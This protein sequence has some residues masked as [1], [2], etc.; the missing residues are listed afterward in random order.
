VFYNNIKTALFEF[1]KENREVYMNNILCLIV[2]G[3]ILIF[4]FINRSI[5]GVGYNILKIFNLFWLFDFIAYAFNIY[6]F[7][8]LDDRVCCYAM[9]FISSTNIFYL[10]RKRDGSFYSIDEQMIFDDLCDNKKSIR[11]ITFLS[12]VCWIFSIKRLMKSIQIIS[13]V[14]MVGLRTMAYDDVTYTTIEKLSYQYFVQ[15]LFV[16]SIILFAI[17]I[18]IGKGK[19]HKKLI[20]V[21]MINATVYSLLFGGRALF[22]LVVMYFFFM[23]ILKSGGR[24]S[25][26]I[27]RQKKMLLIFAILVIV[28]MIYASLRVTRN[29][30]IIGEIGI[31]LT[32]GLGYLSECIKSGNLEFGIL[33]GRGMIGFI[34]DAIGLF[35]KIAGA[36]IKL[37]SEY[38]SDCTNGILTIGDGIR[39]NFTATAMG[40]MLLDFGSVGVLIGGGLYGCL[41][42]RFEKKFMEQQ[43]VYR[44]V[45]YLYMSNIAA[46]SIQNYTLKSVVCLFVFIYA[47]LFLNKNKRIT[48][49]K[50]YEE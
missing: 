19:V 50:K 14:G 7:Y 6:D 28:F 21:A 45:L 1:G 10:L 42:A 40:T 38:Y 29:W 20:L 22:V 34:Y 23:L 13:Q 39:T 30:G 9:V 11:L 32:G 26:L 8:Y 41:F 25:N 35:L 15:P 4:I 33:G 48:I 3:L 17:V 36:N 5:T 27:H 12:V 46:E 31:Y 47:Y 18:I 43:N 16:I 2:I 49:G 44:L 37:V 24:I